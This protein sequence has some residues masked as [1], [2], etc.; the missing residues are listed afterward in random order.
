MKGFI[1][2]FFASLLAVVFLVAVV[3]GVAALKGLE[4]PKIK[5]GSYLVID[6]YGE[7]LPYNPPEDLMAEIM[8]GA[9][10]TLQRILGNLEKVTEDDR[11]TGVILK[12]ST[13]HTLGYASIEEIRNR[14]YDVRSAGKKVFAYAD[15]LD[16]KGL[17]LAAACDSV[18]M[19]RTSELVFVGLGGTRA[20]VRGALDKLGIEPNLHKIDEYKS[21]AE[22]VLRKDMSPEAREMINWIYDDIWDVHMQALSEERGI[23]RD[24]LVELMEYALFIAHEARDAGLI[25]GVRYW[26]QIEEAL[27]GEDHKK[28]RTVSQGAYAEVDRASLGLKGKKK[29]AVVHAHGTIGGRESHVDPMHGIMMGHASLTREL[30][31]V[32]KDDDVAAVVFRVDSPGGEALASDLISRE[33]EL[34]AEAKPVV[35]SMIDVAASGG[36]S[37]SY[38]ATKLVAD[39]MT[40]TGSIGSISG[41]FNVVGLYNKLGI[42]FDFAGKGPNGFLWNPYQNF[43]PEQRKRFEENHWQGFNIWLEDVADKRGIEVEALK[44]LAM[45]RVWTGRQALDN[46]LID[47]VG[48]L[49]RAIELAKELADIPEEDRVTMVHYPKKKGIL[50]MITGGGGPQAAMRWVLYRFIRHD[51]ANSIRMMSRVAM[52]P[53]P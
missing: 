15:G 51:L 23:P 11:I 21:A 9:P 53:V 32:R 48:G 10:E 52:T 50:E 49:D 25:D 16:R 45:G 31:R 14:I 1:K 22:L 43:T 33:V 2:S 35:A 5:D 36:Y 41:K 17:F 30:K 37:I 28:L 6:I 47:E 38:R 19:P 27:K 12:V 44:K 20:Y 42:T 13:N 8:G 18:F 4:K 29:I 40:I 26:D 3:I 46:G 24:K 7:I 34:L 39:P